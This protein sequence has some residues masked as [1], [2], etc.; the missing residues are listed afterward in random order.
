[1]AAASAVVVA[2]LLSIKPVLHVWLQRIEPAEFRAALTLLL[3]SV[4]VLPALPDEGYG[5]L[6]ALNPLEIWRLVVLVAAISFAAYV[7]VKVAGAQRGVLLTGLLGGLVS[8]TS[9]TLNFARMARE[10]ERHTLLAA[11]VLVASATMFLRILVVV[12]ILNPSVVA[13]LVLPF[14]VMSLPL[15]LAAAYWAWHENL[16]PGAELRLSN[17]VEL[18]HALKFG[19]LLALTLLLTKVLQEWWGVSGLYLLAAVAGIADVDAITLSAARMKTADAAIAS[20]A[21]AIAALTNTLTKGL[22]AWTF[23]GKKFG[24]A[25]L[26]PIAIALACGGIVLLS[27]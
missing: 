8:S 18:R 5:P 9:V 21:I 26:T 10:T 6:Q 15:F 20:H 17:P 11:G 14:V 13:K 1:V 12:T 23:G 2:G 16:S 24:F 4:V 22:L 27:F 7:A 25:V 19:A 3:I